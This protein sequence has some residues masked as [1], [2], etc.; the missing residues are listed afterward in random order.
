MKNNYANGNPKR[1]G[2]AILRVDFKSKTLIRDKKGH[3]I[4]IISAEGRLIHQDV[5][6]IYAPSISTSK[7]LKQTLMEPKKE[8]Q[9]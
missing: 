5:T 4:I 8:I 9:Y 1:A 2:V 7:Y 3:Y 6:I